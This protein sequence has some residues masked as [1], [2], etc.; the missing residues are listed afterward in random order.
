MSLLDSDV[1][2]VRISTGMVPF[3][4]KINA[5]HPNLPDFYCHIDTVGEQTAK[6]AGL[7]KLHFLRVLG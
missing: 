4:R 1:L 3:G 6:A 2:V 7:E 5:P